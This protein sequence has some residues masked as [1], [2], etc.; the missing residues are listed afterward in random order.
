MLPRQLGQQ[1][2]LCRHVGAQQLEGGVA[3]V[4]Q[5]VLRA[6]W[7]IRAGSRQCRWPLPSICAQRKRTHCNGC[8]IWGARA[9]LAKALVE[10]LVDIRLLLD[11][12]LLQGKQALRSF[13]LLPLHHMRGALRLL[14]LMAV[15]QTRRERSHLVIQG[16]DA[17]ARL[18][19]ASGGVAVLGVRLAE[20]APLAASARDAPARHR[21][22]A[23]ALARRGA[24]R[25]AGGIGPVI[26]VGRLLP[27]LVRLLAC[28]RPAR[29]L[30][31]LVAGAGA[32]CAR[33]GRPAG[34]RV[35]HRCLRPVRALAGAAGGRRGGRFVAA[36]G[37]VGIAKIIAV[38]IVLGIRI[39]AIALLDGV[40]VSGEHCAF[41][42]VGR[43]P[44]LA[45][46]VCRLA[47]VLCV[48]RLS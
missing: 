21:A 26:G 35:S 39:V 11:H 20:L 45:Q 9:L 15:L 6:R 41:G 48:R 43:K 1:L 7:L 13:L 22:E 24:R 10:E 16:P 19:E 23:N 34:G 18:V 32:G 29:R 2:L 28:T 30:P 31:I 27:I 42:L 3:T 40:N 25:V 8:Q 47:E 14:C 38:R 37:V 17:R 4:A 12:F 36:V 46:G 33:L 44:G 5:F